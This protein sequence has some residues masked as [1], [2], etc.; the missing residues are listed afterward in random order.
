MRG[1]LQILAFNL[2][3]WAGGSLPWLNCDNEKV[4]QL[5]MNLTTNLGLVN[6]LFANKICPRK[7]SIDGLLLS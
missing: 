4:Q 6:D 5:K 2:I 3:Q 7:I 1:D